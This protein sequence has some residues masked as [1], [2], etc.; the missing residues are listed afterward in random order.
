MAN[1]MIVD[2]AGL[3]RSILKK[4]LTRA[5]HNIVF[6]A[7]NGFEAVEGYKEFKPDLV[8]MDMSMPDMGGITA[9]EKIINYDP[10]A[11]I[12]MISSINQ[13]DLVYKAIKAGA[14]H[15]IVKPVSEE[16]TIRIVSEILNKN[17]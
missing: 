17:E 3:I 15:Y 10:G 2:D 8:T 12:I 9:V 6:E 7:T 16:N 1:I 13:K 5:G 11:K 4:Y 14:V